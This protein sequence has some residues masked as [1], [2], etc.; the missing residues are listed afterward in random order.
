MAGPTHGRSKVFEKRAGATVRRWHLL[1]GRVN[2]AFDT[3]IYAYAALCGLRAVRGVKMDKTLALI[4]TLGLAPIADARCGG[5]GGATT[6]LPRSR[7]MAP[8]Q[9]R[10]RAGARC[11][12]KG[13]AP[14]SKVCFRGAK[15][16]SV[17]T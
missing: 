11:S 2:E 14:A 5:S 16:K 3:L 17:G 6:G 15:R 12:H 7:Q 9:R 1:R 10:P 13:N 4:E 8:L